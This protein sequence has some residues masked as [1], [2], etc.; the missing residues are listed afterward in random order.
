MTP[1]TRTALSDAGKKAGGA[2]LQALVMVAVFRLA[3][4]AIDTATTWVRDRR[5]PR[6]TPAPAP[7]MSPQAA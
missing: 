7:Q 4:A 5:R 6:P 1:K 3:D 2:A